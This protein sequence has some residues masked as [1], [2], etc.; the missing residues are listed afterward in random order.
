MRLP[1]VV[2]VLPMNI[3]LPPFDT[4]ITLFAAVVRGELKLKKFDP[5]S[6]ENNLITMQILDAA[7]NSADSGRTI[8]L[9]D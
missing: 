6:L 5:Y 3:R 9:K 2:S 8:E 4:P 7:L 1:K